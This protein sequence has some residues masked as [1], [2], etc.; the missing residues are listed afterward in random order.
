M[1]GR[2]GVVRDPCDSGPGSP[3]SEVENQRS[4]TV[5]R[6][7]KLNKKAIGS[8]V[9]ERALARNGV[10]HNGMIENAGDKAL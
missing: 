5:E 1:G 8:V 3:A 6:I 7:S 4:Q 9:C 2:I 10:K